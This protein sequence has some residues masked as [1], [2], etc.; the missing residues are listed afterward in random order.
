MESLIEIQRNCHEE[1]E[2]CIDLMAKEFMTDKKSVIFQFSEL[3][4]F[5]NGI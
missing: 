1:R 5:K 4:P 3:Y 2:R